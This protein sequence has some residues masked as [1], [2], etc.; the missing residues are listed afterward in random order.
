MNKQKRILVVVDED[1]NYSVYVKPKGA[2]ITEP[3]EKI[4]QILGD[5]RVKHEDQIEAFNLLYSWSDLYSEEFNR[6]VTDADLLKLFKSITDQPPPTT[7]W[8]WSTHNEGKC[9]VAQMTEE[10]HCFVYTLQNWC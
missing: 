8:V 7:P 1:G 6:N 9:S 5:V 10:E 4:L 2:P 3:E